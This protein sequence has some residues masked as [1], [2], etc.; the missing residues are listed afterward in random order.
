MS[1]GTQLTAPLGFKQLQK[2]IRYHVI[3]RDRENERVVL[4]HFEA[5]PAKAHLTFV[6]IRDFDYGIERGQI[7]VLEAE[8]TSRM[9]PWLNNLEGICLDAD[10]EANIAVQDT[11]RTKAQ[12]AAARLAWIQAAVDDYENVFSSLD[13]Q[14]ALN[15]QARALSNRQNESRF[16]LWVIT[17]LAF[18]MN[19]WVLLPSTKGRGTYN[20]ENSVSLGKRMGRPG[21]QGPNHGHDVTAEVKKQIVKAFLKIAK[22]GLTLSTV[23]EN[24]IVQIFKCRFETRGSHERTCI[25]HSTGQPFPTYGQFRY[26]VLKELGHERVWST[27]IGSESYRNSYASPVGAYCEGAQ[28]LMEKVYSDAACSTDFPRS[29]IANCILPRLYEVTI[30][31][32]LTGM[33]VGMG[34]GIGAESERIYRQAL[35]VTALPKSLWG[36][37][38]GLEI[39]D[40]DFPV[41]KMPRVHQTDQGAGAAKAIRKVNASL[42]MSVDMTPAYTPQSNSPIE[43]THDR[44][45]KASGA[46]THKVSNQTA[47][48]M[49]RHMTMSIMTKN[50]ARSVADRLTPEQQG[51]GI[52]SSQELWMYYKSR[53][54]IAGISIKP[55]EVITQYLPKVTFVIK[56]GRLTRNGV[57][58]RSDD[59]FSTEVAKNIRNY[60]GF[61]L[62]GYAFDISNRIE[63]VLVRERLIKVASISNVREHEDARILNVVEMEAHDKL[64]KQNRAMSPYVRR[65]EGVRL[66]VE[67][68]EKTGKAYMQNTTKKGRAKAKTVAARQEMAAMRHA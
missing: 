48:E 16:R 18:A 63:W 19:R 45:S 42:G 37:V 61:E 3:L 54:R 51:H 12:V 53:G 64:D 25:V 40:E 36:E 66:R 43:A 50:R 65:A 31:D 27:L 10:I 47:L 67:S 22:L 11:K 20:R 23:Y 41:Q 33:I 4:A 35:A 17:Y 34:Y 62:T 38:L 55:E 56:K 6:K 68:K 46:P 15:D 2:D 59:F 32:G 1:L 60:E 39:N 14:K 21:Y 44:S 9:P 49:A 58:Y 30:V 29:V 13:P 5:A 26:W 52:V 8:Q 57:V 24:A 28:D 7:L